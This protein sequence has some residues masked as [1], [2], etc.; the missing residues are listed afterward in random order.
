MTITERLAQG[1]IVVLDGAMGSLIQGY[2]LKEKDYR[3]DAFATA[4]AT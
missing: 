4:R 1:D 2:Q 3:G